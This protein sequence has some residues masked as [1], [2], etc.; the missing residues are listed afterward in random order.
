MALPGIRA[1][2]INGE[3]VVSITTNEMEN[4]KGRLPERIRFITTTTTNNFQAG[5]S[6]LP[7]Q[8]PIQMPQIPMPIQSQIMSYARIE[9]TRLEKEKTYGDVVKT[10]SPNCIGKGISGKE[11][12]DYIN[13]LE[14]GREV[15]CRIMIVKNNRLPGGTSEIRVQTYDVNLV[16]M[17]DTTQITKKITGTDDSTQVY[18]PKSGS[19]SSI[20]E[21][22]YKDFGPS[23]EVL[24]ILYDPTT[25]KEILKR[26]T[27][28]IKR[29]PLYAQ[30]TL[31]SMF[32][33]GS[34]AFWN[35]PPVLLRF[36]LLNSSPQTS[37]YLTTTY[38]PGLTTNNQGAQE[39][40]ESITNLQGIIADE[41]AGVNR[42][43][44]D[45]SYI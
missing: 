22:I 4:F 14:R 31:F 38:F 10:L 23:G 17:A 43:N 26:R 5:T 41:L 19:Q 34:A 15:R 16:L 25:T 13:S 6:V 35:Y 7:P 2:S 8:N 42:E 39:E 24:S 37:Q 9:P 30:K 32:Q 28:C 36:E 12:T 33:D 11:F 21:A 44:I 18:A 29:D 40:Y 27:L 1:P 45:E 20:L 3:C